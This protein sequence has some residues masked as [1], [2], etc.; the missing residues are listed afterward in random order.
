MT[1]YRSH[2]RKFGHL[3][4]RWY[5]A[6]SLSRRASLAVDAA[7]AR[8]GTTRSTAGQGGATNLVV[9]RRP[10]PTLGR[11]KRAVTP[12]QDWTVLRRIARLC[13]YPLTFVILVVA[14]GFA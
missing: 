11:C 9:P 4:A 12:L 10:A 13:L 7:E 8:S 1:T 14:G 6:N 5:A 2:F 3:F